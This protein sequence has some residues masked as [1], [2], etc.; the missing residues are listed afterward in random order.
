MHDTPQAL[1]ALLDL[2]RI[3]LE[4]GPMDESLRAVTDTALRVL[5][6]DHA[7]IRLLDQ[8]RT[9]LLSGARSGAGAG[10]RPMSFQPGFGVIGWVVQHGRTARIPDVAVDARY[11]PGTRQGFSIV[12]LLAVPLWSAGHVIGVLS[13]SSP[14]PGAFDDQS[15]MLASLLANCAVPPLERARLERLALTDPNTRAFNQRYLAPKLVE[16]VETARRTRAPLS[17]LLLD[18]DRFKE[19]NDSFGH[20]AGDRVLGA[21]ADILHALVRRGD[22]VVRRGGD[23]F[24]LLLPGADEETAVRVGTRVRDRVAATPFD[25]GDGRSIECTVSVGV[26]VWDGGESAESLERRADRAM[27]G[28][29]Q[30]GRD[31]VET[32]APD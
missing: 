20:P 30:A 29:K 5:P 26:A 1:E 14:R 19:V 16:E 28:A 24:V 9:A 8:D 7:S 4:G 12:S 3:L 15:E 13:L 6:A 23:E 18:I 2:T 22:V 32:A 31:R 25:A 17:L 10:A 21:V 27:Y 11:V